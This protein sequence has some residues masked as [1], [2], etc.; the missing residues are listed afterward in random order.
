[1]RGGLHMSEKMST[2]AAA[3][4]AYEHTELFC[5]EIA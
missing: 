2:F 1:M 5:Q 4:G 3:K